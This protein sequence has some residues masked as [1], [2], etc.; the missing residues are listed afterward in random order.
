MKGRRSRAR[1]GAE[2]HMPKKRL[3]SLMALCFLVLFGLGGQLPVMKPDYPIRRADF[4]H[5]KLED[6]FWAPRLKTNRTVTI[7]FLFKLDE[8]TDRKSV[9]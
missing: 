3:C 7:P 4:A 6:E 5:V 2:D 9:V 8:E 1:I